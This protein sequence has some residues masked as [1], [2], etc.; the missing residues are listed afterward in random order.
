LSK[1][2]SESLPIRYLPYTNEVC[3]Q[4]M[5]G[6]SRVELRLLGPF[7]VR[8]DGLPLPRLRTRKGLQVLALLAMRPST[9]VQREWLAE[10]LWPDSEVEQSAYNLRRSLSDLRSALGSFGN[11]ITAPSFHTLRLEASDNVSID[12]TRFEALC[13]LNDQ[14][15]LREAMDLYRGSLLEGW[16]DEWLLSARS[17][18]EQDCLRALG[19]LAAAAERRQDWTEAEYWLKRIVTID[20]FDEPAYRRLMEVLGHAGNFAA[21][22]LVYRELRV[23]L[24]SEINSDP[25]AETTGLFETLQHEAR[26]TSPKKQHALHSP[27]V[28]SAAPKHRGLPLQLTSFVG[29]DDEKN[30]VKELLVQT[31]LLTLTGSGGCGKTRLALQVASEIEADYPDGVTWLE[32]APATRD[33]AVWRVVAD[34]AGVKEQNDRPLEETICE[35]LVSRHALMVLDNCEHLLRA[36]G[37]VAATLL[38]RCPEL[39][40]V[41]T[42]R[43]P[44]NVT[45]EVNWRVPS[46]SVPNPAVQGRLRLRERPLTARSVME[47]EAVRL[48]ADRATLTDPHFTITDANAADVA[49]ICSRLDGIPL[50]IELAASRIGTLTPTQIASRLHDRFR[51]LK[52][53]RNDL[54]PRQQT[55]RAL[56]DWSYDLLTDLERVLF[57]RLS[58]FVGGWTLE[59]GTAVVSLTDNPNASAELLGSDAPAEVLDEGEIEELHSRLVDKSLVVFEPH[60]AR[61]RMLETIRQYANIRLAEANEDAAVRARHADWFA[62]IAHAIAEKIE[63]PNQ[64]QYYAVLDLERENLRAALE[65][66]IE[67]EQG[68]LLANSLWRFWYV[69]GQLSEASEWLKRGLENNKEASP[70]AR[71]RAQLRAGLFAWAQNRLDDADAYCTASL[72]ASR[73]LSDDAGIAYALLNLGTIAHY[74]HDYAGASRYYEES[75]EIF[76]RLEDPTNVAGALLNMGAAMHSLGDFERSRALHEESLR[77]RRELQDARGISATAGGLGRVLVELGDYPSAKRCFSESVRLKLELGDLYGLTQSMFG[78]A[79]LAATSGNVVGAVRILGCVTK[80]TDELGVARALEVDPELVEQMENARETLGAESYDREWSEGRNMDP[81]IAIRDVLGDA[82]ADPAVA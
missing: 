47:F 80:I 1:V 77:L 51:L 22:T 16:S 45:G 53:G 41:A 55:L 29:R 27:P 67:T 35:V 12:L 40:I 6:A 79:Y 62:N 81:E 32:F 8:I 39:R 17:A 57:R 74:R 71:A 58:V 37:Q 73:K 52:G 49:Q 7:D 3:V 23:L 4:E 24:R 14:K 59:A 18:C 75:I 61:Y 34:A 42:S 50:A 64:G 56:I 11:V 15:A 66:A 76:H 78:V 36:L 25:A 72:E 21:A 19:H 31:R 38:R 65:A 70:R 30:Q 26:S 5:N 48:F 9:E 46:L 60:H 63:G 13:R 28:V 69:R 2:G 82:H 68:L 10:T 43:E 33:D 44:L 54:L 20:A